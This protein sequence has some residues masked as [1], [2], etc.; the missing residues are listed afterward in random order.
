MFYMIVNFDVFILHALY[1][2]VPR[3][4]NNVYTMPVDVTLWGRLDTKAEVLKT[5]RQCG[6]MVYEGLSHVPAQG[7]AKSFSSGGF[8]LNVPTKRTF[9]SPTEVSV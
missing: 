8:P 4:A 6:Y 1:S 2:V 5:V 3:G 9:L 7:A